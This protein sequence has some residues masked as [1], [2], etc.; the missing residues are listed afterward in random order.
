MAMN[1][2]YKKGFLL[3]RKIKKNQLKLIFLE[4]GSI[5]SYISVFP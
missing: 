5:F 1:I 4:N 2:Y 3:N